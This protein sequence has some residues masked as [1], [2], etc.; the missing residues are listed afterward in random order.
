VAFRLPS[1]LLLI[2]R[3]SLENIDDK[4]HLEDEAYLDDKTRLDNRVAN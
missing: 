3:R 2:G 1:P 4:T